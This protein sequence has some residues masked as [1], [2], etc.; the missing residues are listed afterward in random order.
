MFYGKEYAF[1]KMRGIFIVN[2]NFA[3]RFT[4]EGFVTRFNALLIVSIVAENCPHILL[5]VFRDRILYNATEMRTF[6]SSSAA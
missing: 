2:Y 3:C 5:Y 1:T 4:I 6:S